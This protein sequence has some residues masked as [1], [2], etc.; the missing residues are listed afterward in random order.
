MAFS[1][2]QR[3]FGVHGL[4]RLRKY[5][6]LPRP[7]QAPGEVRDVLRGRTEMITQSE[8]N[9]ACVMGKERMLDVCSLIE[10]D[11]IG[12]AEIA[13]MML[14]C[15]MHHAERRNKSLLTAAI[16]FAELVES[17]DE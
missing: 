10:D 9:K 15:M 3:L 16:E 6:D 17:F 8:M 14:G 7:E 5:E 11:D 13:G 4:L 12:H 2:L 1:R